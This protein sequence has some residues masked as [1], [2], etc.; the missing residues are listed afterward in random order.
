MSLAAAGEV[1]H[2]VVNRGLEF[3][4]RSGRPDGSWAIDTNLATWVTTLS[5]NALADLHGLPSPLPPAAREKILDWLIGQQY[6]Q[7]H[8]YTLAAPGGWAWTDLPG[9]VPDADDTA[10]AT[11]A[12]HNLAPDSEPARQAAIRGIHWLADLQNSDG[13]IPTFC[14]GWGNLPFDRSSPDLT[15][16]ALLAW[17][18][19]FDKL[20]DPLRTRIYAATRRACP[21]PARDDAATFPTRAAHAR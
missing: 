19:W 12:L 21:T 4:E 5:V 2:P 14:R 7:V 11:L 9:G 10:G 1:S 8:P 20:T 13:G 18:A 16:H 3:L 15:A 17:S 6:R